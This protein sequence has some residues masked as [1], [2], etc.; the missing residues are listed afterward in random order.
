[1]SE[2]GTVNQGGAPFV[3]RVVYCLSPHKQWGQSLT[4]LSVGCYKTALE[5]SGQE[6]VCMCI[7]IVSGTVKGVCMNVC[8]KTFVSIWNT[9]FFDTFPANG[10]LM[11]GGWRFC[12]LQPDVGTAQQRGAGW[13]RNTAKP[14]SLTIHPVLHKTHCCKKYVLGDLQWCPLCE[15]LSQCKHA[16]PLPLICR[17]DKLECFHRPESMRRQKFHLTNL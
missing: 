15:N 9:P 7:A 8:V 17:G 16:P 14:G 12:W 11:L 1:M 5:R 13:F 6:G 10:L 4:P 3:S 2:T